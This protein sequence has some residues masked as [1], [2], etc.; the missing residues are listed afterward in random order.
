M[1]IYK[2]TNLINKKF[3]IGKDTSSDSNYF[4]SGLL[5]KRAIEK[6]GLENFQKEIID[7]TDNYEELSLKEKYWINHFN[8]TNLKTG[9][10]ISNNEIQDFIEKNIKELGGSKLDRRILEWKP[11]DLFKDLN[12]CITNE[13]IQDKIDT[14]ITN[15]ILLDLQSN[16]QAINKNKP[17]T[18]KLLKNRVKKK[19]YYRVSIPLISDI[20][21]IAITKI[22]YQCGN[23]C[24]SGG[25]L[26]FTEHDGTWTKA[27]KRCKWI[28]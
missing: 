12:N 2:I 5:I 21:K 4:G 19:T 11:C 24:G 18:F 3:Y 25:I 23:E 26:I 10:N 1:Q 13:F 20:Q 6:Y 22:S 17:S 8:S 14:L 16:F 27:D 7:E 15:D 9:Y 28:N